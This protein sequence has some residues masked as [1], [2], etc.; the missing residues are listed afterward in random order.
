MQVYSVKMFLGNRAKSALSA[1][2][3]KSLKGNAQFTDALEKGT[4]QK[5]IK[6][7]VLNSLNWLLKTESL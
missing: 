6:I 2:K 7:T 5:T 1:F 3:G 4:F